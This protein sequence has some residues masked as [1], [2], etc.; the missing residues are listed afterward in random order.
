M[1]LN[2]MLTVHLLLS[3]NMVTVDFPKTRA[4]AQTLE[5]CIPAQNG[6]ECSLSFGDRFFR[7][8]VDSIFLYLL[9]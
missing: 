9:K 7:P 3:S 1:D 5:P 2:V 8:D 6:T 4:L